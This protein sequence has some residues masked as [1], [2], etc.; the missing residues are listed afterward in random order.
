M[1]KKNIYLDNSSSTKPYDEVIQKSKELYED[2]YGNPS[3]LHLMGIQIEREIKKSRETISSYLKCSPNEIVFTSGG[4]ESN[5]IAIQ[6]TAKAYFRNGNHI[7]TTKSEHSSVKDTCSYLMDNGYDTTFLDV[8]HKGHVNK[9]ELE[10]SINEKTILV[11]IMH[12]NNEVGSL[13]YI[14]ELGEIIKNKNKDTIFHVDGVQAYGK[15]PINLKNIDL[16]SASAHKI[17]SLKGT[18]LLYIKKGTKTKPIYYGGSQENFLRPGTENSVGIVCFGLATQISVCNINRNHVH[19]Q[20]LKSN[21]SFLADDKNIFINGDIESDIPYILNMS[22][23]GTKSEV[24]LHLLEIKNIYVSSGSAC[25]SKKNKKN[26]LS[27]YS[28]P[29]NRVDSALRFSFS[30]YNTLEEIEITKKVLLDINE[31][32]IKTKKL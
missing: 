9:E 10:N 21:L 3:S 2:F 20:N 23:I 24:M 5:N 15:I 7:I 22:F 28:L 1:S 30:E 12:V 18:G 25:N 4:T 16:Y 31:E 29:Q 11:S 17:H 6:S 26:I 27:Y 8:D 14:N 32:I 13:N 19:I